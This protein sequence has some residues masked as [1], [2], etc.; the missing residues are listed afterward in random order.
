MDDRSNRG[1]DGGMSIVLVLIGLLA[2]AAELVHLVRLVVR[3]GLGST[4]PPRSHVEELG[5]WATR[6]LRR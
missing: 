4:P 6:Q 2:L 5:P 1:H 3:D